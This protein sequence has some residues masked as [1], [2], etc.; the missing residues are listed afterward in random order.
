MGLEEVG[1]FG[2]VLQQDETSQQGFSVSLADGEFHRLVAEMIVQLRPRHDV[3]GSKAASA[4]APQGAQLRRRPAQ[5]HGRRATADER[6]Q[7]K[8]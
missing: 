3:S 7:A 1:R 5:R 4:V 2:S 6:E 8:K